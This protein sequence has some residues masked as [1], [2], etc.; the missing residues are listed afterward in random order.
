MEMAKKL[1]SD[2]VTNE[3]IAS[4]YLS[5]LVITSAVASVHL[6]GR[7]IKVDSRMCES[8]QLITAVPQ[9][10]VLSPLLFSR[11]HFQLNQTEVDPF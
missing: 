8:H 11:L 1:S 9:G 7:F 6:T 10:S 5:D 4:I 2:L 3:V